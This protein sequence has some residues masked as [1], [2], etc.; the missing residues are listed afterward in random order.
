MMVPWK[1]AWATSG[2]S[3]FLEL[4]VRGKKVF[5]LWSVRHR[6]CFFSGCGLLV[7]CMVG[8]SNMA[9]HTGQAVCDFIQNGEASSML[10]LLKSWPFQYLQ[11]S[12]HNRGVMVPVKDEAS[13]S[14]LN[15]FNLGVAFLGVRVPNTGSILNNRPDHCLVRSFLDLP[16]VYLWIS[17]QES[18]HLICTPIPIQF[19]KVGVDLLLLL[20]QHLCRV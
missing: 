1:G 19:W 10:T 8:E 17:S 4:M 2:G 20:Q 11:R 3:L 14:A 13:N 16:W 5:D 6:I 18:E 9:F 12:L 15:H 7:P